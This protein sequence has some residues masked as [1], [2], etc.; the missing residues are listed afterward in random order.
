[1]K[2]N[3]VIRRFLIPSFIVSIYYLFKFGCYISTKAEVECNRKLIIGPRT[4]ISSFTK[5]KV[6]DGKLHIG[7]DVSI[8][9][10]C[11]ISASIGEIVIGDDCLIS[12]HVQILSSN[13]IYEKIDV[14]FRLQGYT[15]KGVTIGNN[16]WI[17]AGACI[18]D[19]ST[20][21]DGSIITPNSVVSS[22]IPANSIVQ[23]NPGKVIFVRR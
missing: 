14:P 3:K 2:I 1:M 11:N 16:V 22:H 18:L 10:G 12:P 17:G 21:E 5:I 19:G 4:S 8:G 9:T 23:G 20:I 13:Y 7:S 15:S 6:T